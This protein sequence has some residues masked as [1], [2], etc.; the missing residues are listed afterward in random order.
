[1]REAVAE[2]EQ[3]QKPEG[4]LR[5]L[6]RVA[7]SGTV[8]SVAAYAA[9]MCLRLFTNIIL[10]RMLAPENFGLMTLLN[11]TITGLSL[12]SDIGLTPNIIRSKRGDEPEFLNTAWTIQV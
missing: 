9:A 2:V 4:D 5:S 8:W 7:I 10:S 6:G 12:F 1:M 3:T 11:T